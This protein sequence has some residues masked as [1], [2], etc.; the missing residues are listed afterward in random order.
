ME[1]ELGDAG[2][3]GVLALA[4]F[5][6]LGEVADLELSVSLRGEVGIS[7]GVARVEPW[8][9]CAAIAAFVGSVGLS[10]RSVECGAVVVVEKSS[11]RPRVMGMDVIL[12]LFSLFVLEG[13]VASPTLKLLLF[14]MFTRTYGLAMYMP[15]RV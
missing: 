7:V 3:L 13:L 12:M 11:T 6:K 15:I 10:R 2:E 14:C 1:P 4:E 5:M 8:E 9:F